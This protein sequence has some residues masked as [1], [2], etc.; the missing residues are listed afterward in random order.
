MADARPPIAQSATPSGPLAF[1]FWKRLGTFELDLAW[2]PA[3]RR[4]AILGVSGSGKSLTLRLIAGLE[5]AQ[6]HSVTLAGEPIGTQAPEQRA[7]A[8]VPQ[9]YGLF[10]HMTVAEQLAFPVGADQEAARYWT[11]HL[12]L[13]GLTGRH[14]AELSLGQRQRVALGRAFVR[15]S[16]LILLDEP[17]SALDTPR[18]RRLR[19][20]LRQLQAEID[21]TTILVTHDPD[22]AALLADEILVI[23]EG[24]VLQAGRA[25]DLFRRPASLKVAELLGLDNIGSGVM[26]GMGEIQIGDGIALTVPDVELPIGSEVMWRV[27]PEA[28]VCAGNGA[29]EVVVDSMQIR[30]G[31]GHAVF[32]LGSSMLSQRLD[33]LPLTIG[34]RCRIDIPVHAVDVWQPQCGPATNE[35]AD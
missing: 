5:T 20:L 4:L 35:G 34:E 3:A 18:R 31:Q 21:A 16:R 12:G 7:V 19:H 32:R 15:H 25:E 11:T 14:P 30:D 9:D 10:P 29:Y 17:F 28:L 23:D 24:R 27:R 6:V 26:Q 22:E 1:R 8:Y 13:S 33:G 2:S